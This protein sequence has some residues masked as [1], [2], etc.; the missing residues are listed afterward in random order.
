MNRRLFRSYRPDRYF[1]DD[2]FLEVYYDYSRGEKQ[3]R[4]TGALRYAGPLTRQMIGAVLNRES[5]EHGAIETFQSRV[6]AGLLQCRMIGLDLEQAAKDKVYPI[7]WGALAGYCR[8]NEPYKRDNARAT[9]DDFRASM[10]LSHSDWAWLCQKSGWYLYHYFDGT[11]PSNIRWP[12]SLV[13]A[14]NRQVTLPPVKA[15]LKKYF[16]S[17]SDREIDKREF[18]YVMRDLEDVGQHRHPSIL[19]GILA[20]KDWGSLVRALR[21]C[22]SGA[23][24][25][26]RGPLMSATANTLWDFQ[27]GFTV[28]HNRFLHGI[29]GHDESLL[30]GPP[31]P[32]PYE[33]L[34]PLFKYI[35]SST[36][37]TGQLIDNKLRL[38]EEGRDM[39]HCIWR[40]YRD[41]VAMQNY[42]AYHIDAPQLAKEG[43]TL[44]IC[45]DY[46]ISFAPRYWTNVHEG[47]PDVPSIEEEHKAI[48]WKVDQIRGIANSIPVYAELDAF[49]KIICQQVNEVLR[50]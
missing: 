2:E 39:K 48:G 18:H 31:A 26:G 29:V 46:R 1:R 21:V 27:S 19:K 30:L 5:R 34:S 42:V 40:S 6:C 43:Y 16:L 24:R 35:S 13:E 47:R 32:E 12:A 22:E 3:L 41:R 8:S 36:G 20:Q 4:A 37:M 50:V 11:A 25:S 14:P 17:A 10:E 33:F 38:Y 44:G 45:K 9:I 23:V 15:W 7:F 49:V 28:I